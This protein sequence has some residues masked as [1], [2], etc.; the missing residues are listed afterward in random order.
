[1]KLEQESSIE[2]CR[3]DHV[4]PDVSVILEENHSVLSMEYELHSSTLWYCRVMF[5]DMDY[6][7]LQIIWD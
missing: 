5:R 2:Y 4:R 7:S 6:N 1:M 3:A